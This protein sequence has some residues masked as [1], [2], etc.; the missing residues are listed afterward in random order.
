MTQFAEEVVPRH[1]MVGQKMP[2]FHARNPGLRV[3]FWAS[4]CRLQRPVLTVLQWML[5]WA[6]QRA[7]WDASG[8]GVGV[9]AD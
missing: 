2:A 5:Q 9:V 7:G 1:E 8:V 4:A 6:I 3:C